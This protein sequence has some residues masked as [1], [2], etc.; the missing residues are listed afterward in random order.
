MIGSLHDP[1]TDERSFP[2][3]ELPRGSEEE[4]AR[5]RVEQTPVT[6]INWVAVAIGAFAVLV[7]AIVV[8][9]YLIA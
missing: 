6:M 5:G 7:L 9:A 1:G 3:A 8:A 4:L 2:P